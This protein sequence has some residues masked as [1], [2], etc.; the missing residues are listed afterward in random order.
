MPMK[1]SK[2]VLA[3]G[4]VDMA[5]LLWPPLYDFHAV[6]LCQQSADHRSGLAEQD[7]AL[8]VGVDTG[9]RAQLEADRLALHDRR[10]LPYRLLE[11]LLE[12]GK[13]L[14]LLAEGLSSHAPRPDR[15]V[16]D[17]EVARDIGAIGQPLVEH[18]EQAVDLVA[19]AILGVLELLDRIELRGVPVEGGGLAL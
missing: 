3:L 4:V 17:R 6:T 14:Q 8:L 18:A 2:S 1:K 11:P 10:P 12:V 15:H 16:G 5:A 9:L 7:L 19:V 13:I